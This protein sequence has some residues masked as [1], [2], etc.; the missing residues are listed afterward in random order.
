LLTGIYNFFGY[1]IR[2]CYSFLNNWF[3]NYFLCSR[4]S[5][6]IF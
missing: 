6:I 4:L 1:R 3:L 2:L 5:C